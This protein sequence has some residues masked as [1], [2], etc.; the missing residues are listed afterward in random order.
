MSLRRLG[1]KICSIHP[2]LKYVCKNGHLRITPKENLI[3]LTDKDHLD[4]VL[5]SGLELI[6]I[7]PPK[8]L[9]SKSSK[10]YT[11]KLKENDIFRY[12]VFG[13]GVYGNTGLSYEREKATE[14]EK[15][16]ANGNYSDI[17]NNLE[18]VTGQ[19]QIKNIVKNFNFKPDRPL[20]LF[21]K[22]IGN[23]VS[24]II[25]E[26]ENLDSIFISL[27][28]YNGKTISN[29][30]I[31][32]SFLESDNGVF[33]I[34]GFNVDLLLQ[35]FKIDINK[36]IDGLNHYLLKTP[37]CFERNQ[38][39]DLHYPENIKDL[40][41]AAYG[42]GYYLVKETKTDGCEII[43]LTTYDKLNKYI[44]DVVSAELSYPYFKNDTRL[45]KCKSMNIKIKTDKHNFQFTLRN[46][47]S[48]VSPNTFELTKI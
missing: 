15:Y 1:D 23:V 16:I 13:L 5:K 43:D 36:M 41:A 24:D 12:V 39:I 47:A 9:Y 34:P 8:N 48:N 26:T 40:I 37:S 27:K 19:L 7:I 14:I 46:R 31:S 21:P 30:G 10:F 25:L 17:I 11:Y 6:E 42:Y 3:A 20:D 32:N 45:G 2:N 33:Y 4:L 35:E 29:H 18:K 38:S 44:G 28:S 22:N